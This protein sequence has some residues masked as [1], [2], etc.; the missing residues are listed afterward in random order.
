MSDKM[1]KEIK[2]EIEKLSTSISRDIE[3]LE[4]EISD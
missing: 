4:R 1:K 2:E 3:D